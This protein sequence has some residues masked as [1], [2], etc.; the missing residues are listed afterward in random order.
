MPLKNYNPIAAAL[1]I[2]A[3][4]ALVIGYCFFNPEYATS[5]LIV[6]IATM[7]CATIIL[8]VAGWIYKKANNSLDEDDI[9]KVIEDLNTEMII[10]ADDFSYVYI[11]KKLRSLLG[12]DENDSNKKAGIWKA[13]G[14]NA[15]DTTALDKIAVNHSY[16]SSFRD[17]NGALI[18][19]AWSTSL[20]RKK[21]KNTVYLSTGFNLTELKKMKVNLASANDFF[22]SSMELAEIGVIMSSDRKNY[23]ASREMMRMLG[24][25]SSN[26]NINEFRSLIHPNDRIQFDGAIKSADSSEIKMLEVR[27]KSAD[28]SYRWY[29]YRFKFIP[30]TGNT[31]PLFGGAIIDITQEHEKDFLIE[32]LAYIDEVTEIANRNKLLDSG[33]EIYDSCKVLGYS[34]WIIVLDIDRF[35]IINDACGYNNG[36]YVLRNFAHILYKFVTPGG[37]AARI[38]GDNFALL[39][40]DYGDDDMPI[41]TVKSIQDEF[42][43]LAVDNLASINLSCSAGYSKMPEDGESFLDV[44]E[45]AEFALK[46]NT[47]AQGSICAYESS[48]HDSI[49][50]NTELEKSLALA[51]KNN[52][53]HL[54][55]QPKID[56]STGKI[57][58]VE[59]LIRWI[60]PDGTII[61]PDVFVPIAESSHLI[62][63]ISEFVLNEGC[64]QNKLW[65][66]MGYPNIVMSINFASSDF[67]QTDL[68]DKVFEAL[69]RSGLNAQWLEVELTET[70]ALS[71]INYAVSQMNKLRELGVKLAMD[72]FGTGYSSLSYL[73]ILPITLLKLD[74]SFITDIEHDNIA[75]EIVSAVIRI[76][77]S[78]KI[79]TIAEGIENNVQESILRMAGCDYAQG[80]LYGKP[81]PPEKIQ[82][83]FEINAKSTQFGKS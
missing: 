45:H 21:K 20:I 8:S 54:F 78:K 82:E 2:V 59:A 66:K 3:A 65:Q 32:R 37:L 62:G 27:M 48:M 64:R 81:M 36:N 47:E 58:G 38:S 73:Q 40:R 77:K 61:T 67:Y 7:I 31:L 71:D 4:T 68:K 22:N 29:S 57:M 83:F 35:H 76:A 55:Y 52:E 60:K 74:R 15:P 11:N 24:L 69:A 25:K 42:S 13:F 50:G 75:Y 70:L 44:M 49:I 1:I 53:L 80:Y 16:E 34:F 46:S 79:E 9:T 72:D 39:L 28:G 26:I 12:I 17:P 10:W 30:G 33:Q 5:T 19:I 41:R 43:K 18:S 63:K 14:I 51:I 56:L 6:Y 23:R